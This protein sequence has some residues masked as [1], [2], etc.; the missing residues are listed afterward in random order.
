MEK[1]NKELYPLRKRLQRRIAFGFGILAVG[2][3]LFLLTSNYI[4]SMPFA[5]VSTVLFFFAGILAHVMKKNLFVRV[6][7]I[8]EEIK[9]TK[10]FGRMKE[11]RMKT[12]E[13][14]LCIIVRRRIQGLECGKSMVL[15]LAK[16]AR[17]YE[18]DGLYIVCSYYA[19]ES[20]QD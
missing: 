8:C 13:Y 10:L 19:I 15:F 14:E 11:I 7:G 12:D 5:A 17:L 16:G 9:R 3:L 4:Y 1:E 20:M 18:K 2:I 6:T